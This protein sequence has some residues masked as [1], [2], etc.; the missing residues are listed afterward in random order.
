MVT[1]RSSVSIY[2]NIL[3]YQPTK[4]VAHEDKRL[5]TGVV[6]LPQVSKADDQTKGV[7]ADRVLRDL[8]ACNSGVVP[9]RYDPH[10]RDLVWEQR[11]DPYVSC[12]SGLPSVE[13]VT[14]QTVEKDD[15]VLF[16]LL[17]AAPSLRDRG[18]SENEQ[19]ELGNALAPRARGVDSLHSTRRR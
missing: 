16:E 11:L 7:I 14:R 13:L 3:N 1:I 17:A 10:V 4:Q 12:V 2:Y 15:A 5:V 18:W 19:D 9:E 6:T 8:A